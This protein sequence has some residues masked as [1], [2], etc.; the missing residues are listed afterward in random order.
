MGVLLGTVY[1]DTDLELLILGIASI[2]YLVIYKIVYWWR[3]RPKDEIALIDTGGT[4]DDN[5]PPALAS[6]DNETGL[7]LAA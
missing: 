3:N 7:R 5:I 2:L 6:D 1:T 4:A